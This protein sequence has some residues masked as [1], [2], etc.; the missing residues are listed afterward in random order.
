[1]STSRL[2]Y[3]VSYIIL[4]M[5]K[6]VTA[7]APVLC[8]DRN[9]KIIKQNTDLNIRNTMHVQGMVPRRQTHSNIILLK[10]RT[11]ECFM[12]DMTLVQNK[13]IHLPPPI[14]KSG[15]TLSAQ[16]TQGQGV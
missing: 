5:S 11:S 2:L 10:N 3:N 4:C 12:F 6:L 13:S 9:V 14:L 15:E 16:E 8:Q 1:M 7:H